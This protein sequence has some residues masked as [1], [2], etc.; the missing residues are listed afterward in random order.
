MV[1]S[2]RCW[3]PE[4][5]SAAEGPVPEGAWG[6]VREPCGGAGR[7]A[8]SPRWG[9][10][11]S[12]R[13]RLGRARLRLLAGGERRCPPPGFPRSLRRS[14]QRSGP[15]AGGGAERGRAP[16]LPARDSGG[17]APGPGRSR[18]RGDLGGRRGRGRC[19]GRAHPGNAGCG[20]AGG[21]ARAGMRGSGRGAAG[22]SARSPAPARGLPEAAAGGRRRSPRWARGTGPEGAPGSGRCRSCW[23]HQCG[24]SRGG[25]ARSPAP[26]QADGAK[27]S[28]VPAVPPAPAVPLS[29]AAL[30]YFNSSFPRGDLNVL[31]AVVSKAS[32]YSGGAFRAPPAPG[33]CGGGN[34]ARVAQPP[35]PCPGAGSVAAAAPVPP[36]WHGC[37]QDVLSYR[38]WT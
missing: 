25:A 30:R 11:Q 32:Q 5:P 18:G 2:A 9:E 24:E 29:S 6:T 31:P 36:P 27:G 23:K 22:S 13:G 21:C 35:A 33:K 3:A 19:R 20:A 26:S 15:G 1:W 17:S 12:R 14:R 38:H 4:P 37:R 16:A 28:R 34:F 7:G 8:A 10:P